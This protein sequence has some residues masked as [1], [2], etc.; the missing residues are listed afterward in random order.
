MTA[1][2]PLFPP[3][4]LFF[5]GKD[6]TGSYF[7]AGDGN[8]YRFSRLA[9]GGHF[10]LED[11]CSHDRYWWAV[12]CAGGLGNLFSFLGSS[13]FAGGYPCVGRLGGFV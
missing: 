5:D 2:L 12:G 4:H 11:V 3:D 8:H 7:V 6:R 9:D 13:L 10:F 1:G